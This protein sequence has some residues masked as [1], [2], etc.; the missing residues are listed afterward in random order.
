MEQSIKP[1]ETE[2]QARARVI[3]DKVEA[4]R[5]ADL[6][7]KID[8][9]NKIER[10]IEVPARRFTDGEMVHTLRQS[11][12][13]SGKITDERELG[14]YGNSCRAGVGDYVK[15]ET[16]YSQKEA[17]IFGRR[18]AIE[19]GTELSIKGFELDAKTGGTWMN[20]EITN[21]EHRDKMVRID[22][23][24]AQSFKHSD[25]YMKFLQGNDG[26][27]KNVIKQLNG[28]EISSLKVDIERQQKQREAEQKAIVKMR[29]RKL[30]KQHD[31]GRGFSK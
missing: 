27:R 21:G 13:E 4:E 11:M 12:K 5:E 31:K 26:V 14:T 30:D 20:A 7:A 16:D 19:S 2:Y 29:E 24:V 25:R 28:K 9:L 8:R 17:G 3:L 10:D 15:I 22:L 1:K 6:Q 18:T 23:S